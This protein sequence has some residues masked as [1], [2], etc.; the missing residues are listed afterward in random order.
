MFQDSPELGL[1]C[2]H[3]PVAGLHCNEFLIVVILDCRILM[4]NPQGLT[5]LHAEGF[6]YSTQPIGRYTHLEI[7][8]PRVLS[9][10]FLCSFLCSDLVQVCRRGRADIGAAAS[11][12]SL[13]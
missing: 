9:F 5:K 8:V 13:R 3:A 12:W 2:I 11:E 6:R 1:T 4:S 10:A 7:G